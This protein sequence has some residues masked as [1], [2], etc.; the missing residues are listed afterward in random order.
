MRLEPGVLTLYAMAEKKHPNQ[1]SFLDIYASEEASRNH[2][3][4]PISRNT[5][6]GRSIWSSRSNWLIPHHVSQY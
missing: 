2:I 1:V 3:R 4:L 5:V 6:R